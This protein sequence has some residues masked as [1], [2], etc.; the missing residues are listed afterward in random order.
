MKRAFILTVLLCT[1]LSQGTK[2]QA[3]GMFNMFYSGA[4]GTAPFVYPDQQA[5]DFVIDEMKT[6]QGH[7]IEL[8]EDDIR[9]AVENNVRDTLCQNKVTTDTGNRIVFVTGGAAE[10][11]S[12]LGLQ[13][14]IL[15]LLKAEQEAEQLGT[16]LLTIANGSE[17]AIANEPHRPFEMGRAALL[18][19][20]TW[21]GTGSAIIPWD[22]TA[23]NEVEALEQRIGALTTS[24]EYD[25]A[26]LRYHHGYFRD[27]REQDPTFMG[28]TNGI[29]EALKAI[30]DKL[31]ITGDP[32]AVGEFATPKL[33]SLG[34]IAL[35]AR[36]D[37]LGLLYITPVH[38]PR[39]KIERAT[40][41]PTM[42]PGGEKLAYP[43]SYRG[44]TIPTDPNIRSPLCSRT[45]GRYGYLCRTK[46]EVDPD[47]AEDVDDGITLVKCSEETTNTE[48]GPKECTDLENLYEDTG[49]PLADPAGTG[50]RNPALVPADLSTICTPD[51]KILYQ[52][53]IVSHTCYIGH[54][55][56]QSMMEHTL[57]PNR[58]TVLVNENTSPYLSCMRADPALGK[59][60]E[61]PHETPYIFPAYIG[62]YLAM[63]FER[64]YCVKNGTI[65]HPLAGFCAYRDNR[66]S[67]S[68]D[69]QQLFDT[70]L[71]RKDAL[72]VETD[73]ETFVSLGAAI[74]ER[75]ALD[76]ALVV[77][78]KVF[79]S[80]AAF[81]Q[82]VA[83]LF[84]ELKKAPI[85]TTP[86]PW[87]GPFR[88]AP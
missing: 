51:T 71:T 1:L 49:E 58:N 53:D 84:M 2:V 37:D 15:S 78:R 34:N 28:V 68:P 42:V 24:T 10:G 60:M 79:G 50:Q 43:F 8:T 45:V 40:D 4:A 81:V 80:F 63:D 87:T 32:L 69:Y 35:W 11:E 72:D 5:M 30:A 22:G 73:Q 31:K 67:N 25:T 74:G 85:T 3:A 48:S 46:P 59:Y 21:I 14:D 83:D 44:T 70:V 76:Q 65:P 29:G 6:W 17:L 20:R 75:A 13:R 39:L 54:C 86:C 12:C 38:F 64:E 36:G 33:I 52:D 41:Y 88:P 7:G 56:I 18:V 23:D 9:L 57:V 26:M 61:V 19:E 27:K 47:C 82:Q 66:K 62:H 55:L 16:D 77:E